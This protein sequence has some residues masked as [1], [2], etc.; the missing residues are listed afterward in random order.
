MEIVE[1]KIYFTDLEGIRTIT[2]N[3]P[4]KKNAFDQSMFPMLASIL[5]EAQVDE[6]IKV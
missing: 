6:N 2:L 5:E 3:R 4:K 1:N